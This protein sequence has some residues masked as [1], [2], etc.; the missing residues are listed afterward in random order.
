MKCVGGIGGMEQ[1]GLRAD[2]VDPADVLDREI[3]RFAG[4]RLRE[5]L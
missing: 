1:Y 5:R 4:G 2:A 3:A